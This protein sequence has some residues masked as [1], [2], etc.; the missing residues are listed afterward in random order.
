MN[1]QDNLFIKNIKKKTFSFH[2]NITVHPQNRSS[3]ISP[4]ES[5]EAYALELAKNSSSTFAKNVENFICCTRESHE[6]APQVVMRNM[7]QFMSGMK[8]YL[9]KHGEGNFQNEVQQACARLKPNEFLNLDTI[10]ENVMHILVVLP[11]KEHLYRLFVD[12]YTNSGDL[13]LLIDNIKIA[14]ESCPADLGIEVRF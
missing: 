10:L 9:V 8:N 3:N 7:R 1:L 11:L 13:K 6:T 14:S 2:Y 12:F 4:G 5:V